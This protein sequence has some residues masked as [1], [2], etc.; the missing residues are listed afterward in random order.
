MNEFTSTKA[1]SGPLPDPAQDRVESCAQSASGDDHASAR[2]PW[3]AF[4][5]LTEIGVAL[6]EELPALA[7]A[8]SQLAEAVTDCLRKSR[9]DGVAALGELAVLLHKGNLDFA[10][11]YERICRAVR[12]CIMLKQHLATGQM[13]RARA[14]SGKRNGAAARSADGH[15]VPETMAASAREQERSIEQVIAAELRSETDAESLYGDLFD[16]PE[17]PTG[18]ADL[19][20]DRPLAAIVAQICADF[21]VDGRE[22]A[23]KM[24][25]TD[26]AASEGEDAGHDR[27]ERRS[28][29]PKTARPDAEPARSSKG[30]RD[31]D[32]A[33]AAP[34]PRLGSGAHPSA[35]NRH[36]RRAARKRGQTPPKT[37][38][39]FRPGGSCGP[40]G[41]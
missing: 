9:P 25:L 28:K 15:R 32:P 10:Q 36:Q 16:R 3:A 38:N 4:D 12:R 8:Q 7:R 20:L 34:S 27:R 23:E 39:G 22:W 35:L 30:Q 13:L 37:A 19:G 21:G 1:D 41:P 40:P 5:K 17:D 11:M 29:A 24:G 33:R 2:N 26:G 31:D 14:A 18:M 6:A